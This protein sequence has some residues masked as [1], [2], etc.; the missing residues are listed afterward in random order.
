MTDLLGGRLDMVFT[1]S[2]AALVASGKVRYLAATS[3]K[4][5]PA[6]P[7]LPALSEIAPGVQAVRQ[8]ALRPRAT[9]TGGVD[10]GQAAWTASPVA[11]VSPSGGKSS[12]KKA[13]PRPPCW[14]LWRP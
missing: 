11:W 4:R 12:A 1:S 3:E 14:R 6:Y 5:A 8:T 7:D 13:R 9:A 10:A 2:A